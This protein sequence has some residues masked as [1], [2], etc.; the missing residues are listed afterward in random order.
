MSVELV[1][2]GIS[3]VVALAG[4]ALGGRATRK[5]ALPSAELAQGPPAA[6]G[7]SSGRT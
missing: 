6:P 7:P 5:Q 2:A 1:V 3:G 4:V